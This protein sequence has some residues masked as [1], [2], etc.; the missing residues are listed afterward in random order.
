MF[1]RYRIV[2]EKDLAEAVGKLGKANAPA[3][4]RKISK[5]KFGRSN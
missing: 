4:S 2:N 5:V 1:T 3:A